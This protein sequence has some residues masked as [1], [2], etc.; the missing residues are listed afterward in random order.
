MMNASS[1]SPHPS[2]AP[3]GPE[4]PGAASAETVD[5]N[6]LWQLV[7]ARAWVVALTTFLALAVAGVYLWRSPRFYAAQAVLEVEAEPRRVTN[8]E[9][10]GADESKSAEAL[11]T[12]EGV[13]TNRALLTRVVRANHLVDRPAFH[14]RLPGKG[15]AP[16]ETDLV[17]LLG[18]RVSV[19][20][21]RGSRLI[22]LTVQDRDPEE[23]RRLAE[24]LIGEFAAGELDN[25]ADASKLAQNLLTKQAEEL[26]AKLAASERDLQSYRERT[27]TVSLEETQNI[28]AG[29]L[30]D[31]NT[32]VTEAKARRIELESA[33]SQLSAIP[34][35]KGTGAKDLERLLQVPAVSA[36]PEVQDLRNQLNAREAELAVIEKRYLYKHPRN[37]WAKNQIAQVRAALGRATNKAADVVTNSYRAAKETE[38]SLGAALHQQEDAAMELGRLSGPYNVL[39]RQNQSD[40]AL[41]DAVLTRLKQTDVLTGVLPGL[42][43]AGVR[44]IETP[45]VSSRLVGPRK[46]RT[47][48]LALAAG[49]GV[50]TGVA[51]GLAALDGSLRT[52]EQTEELLGLPG[53]TAVPETRPRRRGDPPAVRNL[54][55]VHQPASAAAEAFRSLRTA[56]ALEH[57]AP[58]SVLF[59]SAEPGEGKSFCSVN[60]AAALAQQGL[61]TLFVSADLRC[62]RADELLL[63]PEVL[64]RRPVTGLAD[65]LA[66]PTPLSAAVYPTAV[67]NLFICPAGQQVPSPAELL[68]GGRFPGVLTEALAVFDRVVVDSPPL[69]AV[70]DCL[71]L[72]KHVGAVCVVIRAR[73]TSRRLVERACRLLRRA[74]VQP[75]GFVLNRLTADSSYRRAR[76][77]Y[78]DYRPAVAAGAPGAAP[79]LTG[80]RNA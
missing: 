70:S 38:D 7:R 65:C 53:L 5:F 19:D 74:G 18:Y 61:T 42:S 4:A 58:R 60:H 56:L 49:L 17:D 44:V 67:A 32:K 28:I 27:N 12:V 33:I 41:Y 31:L 57:D 76:A 78:G 48:L 46:L 43:H 11:K 34:A 50:G 36:A 30:R 51:V 39:L 9:D 62:P 6:H 1:N 13:L 16:T 15:P 55:V 59:T 23:A 45:T 54:P 37:I 75:V 63:T 79:N 3:S 66:G 68:A 20:L 10:P 73:K 64:K 2:A 72:A 8:F 22:D 25:R 26:R 47:L 29:K 80:G 21:R 24:S 71:L 35:V 69:V 40:R 14:G 77:H 52:V